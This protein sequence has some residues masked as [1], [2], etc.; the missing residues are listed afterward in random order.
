MELYVKDYKT[1][2]TL[3][4]LTPITTNGKLDFQINL[5]EQRIADS[6][7]KIEN[8]PIVKK[9]N[10]LIV[11]G[12]YKQFLF[13]IDRAEKPVGSEITTIYAKHI[14]NI[15]NKKVF[16][17]E[18]GNKSLEKHLADL[19][20]INFIHSDD[21]LF[22]LNYIDTYLRTYTQTEYKPDIDNRLF[23]LHTYMIN[24][25]QNKRVSTNF[26]ISGNRLKVEFENKQQK[27]TVNIN[28]DLIEIINAKTTQSTNLITKV[29]AYDRVTGK[30]YSLFLRKDHTTTENKY[31]DKRLIGT[32][33][34]ISSDS[35][36][37]AKEEAL[38]VFKGN[39]YNHLFE[40]QLPLNSKLVNTKNL[41]LGDKINIK[42]DN[43]I[44][45][46]YI[47]G[48]VIED[49][50]LI[51]VKTG[52]LKVLL[53]D[54][55]KELKNIKSPILST[56]NNKLDTTGGNITGS[57]T[58]KGSPVITQANINEYIRPVEEKM[59]IMYGYDGG[60]IRQEN[61]N[62]FFKSEP[63][64][65]S[66]NKYSDYMYVNGDRIS[67]KKPIRLRV[68]FTSFINCSHGYLYVNVLHYKAS[69]GQTDI[70]TNTID[71][72]KGDF[73][74]V[75]TLPF[76]RVFEKNDYMYVRLEVPRN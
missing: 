6:I 5:D 46:S 27:E 33:E 54:K 22:N 58:V 56:T 17:T 45:E 70:I 63:I 3:G 24:C 25:E 50:N 26:K 31:D 16:E 11:N 72:S 61:Y 37:K 69:T 8:N 68:S 57:L 47:S 44:Y 19:I 67:F 64:Y 35:V 7:F 32:T 2:E 75:T 9:N 71:N 29:E 18:Q 43:I 38:N 4:V 76:Y 40:F 1:F 73:R 28:A 15:F 20:D 65:A 42:I 21:A 34:V 52:N 39:R 53:T 10:F 59:S 66:S 62:I 30:K 14:S 12:L 49:S 36:E 51:E 60:D 23:N 74:S 55:L 13:T 48:L 41:D